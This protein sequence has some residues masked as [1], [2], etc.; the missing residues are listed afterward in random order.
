MTVRLLPLVLS[1]VVMAGLSRAETW[2]SPDGKLSVEV[3]DAASFEAIADAPTPF[4]VVWISSDGDTKLGV[5]KSS[6][7]ANVKLVQTEVEEGLAKEI[8]GKV[9][10]LPT[11]TIGGHEV[12]LMKGTGS[13]VEITQALVRVD[14]TVHKVM[15]ITS[16][17]NPHAAA[18]NRFMESLAITEPANS[19]A[20]HDAT[21]APWPPPTEPLDTHQISKAIGGFFSLLLIGLVIYFVLKGRRK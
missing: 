7:P 17:E 5:M 10:R 8:G 4:A 12:W 14:D 13:G 16:S 6:V 19:A 21:H 11:K 3:P 20:A 9:T 15:A 2:N 18:V 1:L